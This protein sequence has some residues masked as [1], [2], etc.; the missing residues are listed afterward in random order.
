MNRPNRQMRRR[1]DKTDTVDAEA[2]ARAAL[3]GDAAVQPK[4][5]DGCVEAIRTLTVARRSAVKARTVAA[6]QISAITVTATARL[7]NRL[8]QLG[9]AALVRSCARLRP[10]STGDTVSGAVKR[11]L[12]HLARR[13]QM[14]T[15]ETGD[16]D[17][18]LRRLCQQANPALLCTLGVGHPKP[19]QRCSP[20]QATIQ[21]ACAAKHPS[22]LCAVPVPSRL[23]QACAAVTVSTEAA[24]AALTTPCGA[25]PWY[26][27]VSTSAAPPCAQRRTTE[28]KTRRDILRC[29]KR[30]IAREVYK[31]LTNPPTVP[32]GADL[33]QQRTSCG[34]SITTIATA[35]NT[36]PTRIS[37]LERGLTHNR[38]LAERYQRCLTQNQNQKKPEPA[39]CQT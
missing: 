1:R 14:L 11:A 32:H 23:P 30:Y 38:E 26:A 39:S 3:N 2:A 34:L 31:L 19:P 7:R 25:S 33:R 18:Q 29:L 17:T 10:N 37:E 9:P 12:R 35:L 21:N 8:Q 6:N 15:A 13:H 22:P 20:P 16:L 4:S 28:G 24:I 5:G 36:T 27:C